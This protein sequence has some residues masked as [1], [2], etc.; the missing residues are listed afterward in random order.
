M[1]YRVYTLLDFILIPGRIIFSGACCSCN[2]VALRGHFGGWQ[3]RAHDDTKLHL[4]TNEKWGLP[5]VSAEKSEPRA[6]SDWKSTVLTPVAHLDLA[7]WKILSL[8]SISHCWPLYRWKSALIG[9]GSFFYPRSEII[10]NGWNVCSSVISAPK[11]KLPLQI[12]AGDW[13]FLAV[14]VGMRRETKVPRSIDRQ[15]PRHIL[16]W[17]GLRESSQLLRLLPYLEPVGIFW[18]SR[19]V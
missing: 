11:A 7:Y 18:S 17:I 19:C 15:F 6:C 13:G 16:L 4:Y 3:D 2:V 10:A 1:S 14:R 8:P 12:W 9:R 5:L